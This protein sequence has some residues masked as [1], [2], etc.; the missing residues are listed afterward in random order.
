MRIEI[1]SIRKSNT[2]VR[3]TYYTQLLV[4]LAVVFASCLAHAAD[5][6]KIQRGMT[7][8]QVQSALG[9]PDDIQ[10][11]P[12]HTTWWKYGEGMVVLADGQVVNV[13][14]NTK[15]TAAKIQALFNKH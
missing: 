12:M 1:Q 14:A 5:L 4:L 3:T 10:Q 7:G 6:S 15:E 2:I 9:K 8:D 13:V 11:L